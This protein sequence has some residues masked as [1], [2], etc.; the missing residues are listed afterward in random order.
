MVMLDTG[1]QPILLGLRFATA[2]GLHGD[3]LRPSSWRIRTAGGTIEPVVGE[4]ITTIPI[5][6]NGGTP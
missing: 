6:F 4:S 3:Q 1:A 5:L 2:I